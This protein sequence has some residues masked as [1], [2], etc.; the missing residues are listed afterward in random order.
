M[1][2]WSRRTKRTQTKPISAQ[3]PLPARQKPSLTSCLTRPYATTPQSQKQSQ[4]NPISPQLHNLSAAKQLLPSA[5]SYLIN[6]T[7]AGLFLEWLPV[8]FV[9]HF[10]NTRRGLEN[11][12]QPK[13]PRLVQ[14]CLLWSPPKITHRQNEI[15]FADVNKICNL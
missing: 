4:T 7:G 2:T 1:D 11:D 12:R 9:E 10:G 14:I 5:L 15:G 13:I 6:K 8:V 3:K